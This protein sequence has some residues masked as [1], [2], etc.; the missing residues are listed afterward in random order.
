MERDL[1]VQIEEEAAGAVEELETE[2]EACR[3]SADRE[4]EQARREAA[5]AAGRAS[6]SAAR[7]LPTVPPCT[8]TPYAGLSRVARM[9]AHWITNCRELLT[10]RNAPQG[11]GR[12]SHSG[13]HTRAGAVD[14]FAGDLLY[15]V[16]SSLAREPGLAGQLSEHSRCVDQELRTGMEAAASAASDR[17]DQ[18]RGEVRRAEDRMRAAEMAASEAAS[19]TG[20]STK[21]LLRQIEAMAAAAVRTLSLLR[22]GATGAACTISPQCRAEQLLDALSPA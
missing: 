2:L 13:Q 22:S 18:L 8:V 10:R 11:R 14:K 7:W 4:I 19:Q 9:M 6:S 17:E 5:D 21:P 3:L 20:D 1:A 16:A 12:G 15:V